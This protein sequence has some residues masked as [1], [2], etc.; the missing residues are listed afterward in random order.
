MEPDKKNILIAEDNRVMAGVMR[1]KLEQAGFFVVVCENGV[2][3]VAALGERQ[4]DVIV[5]DYQMPE[6]NGEQLC[7]HARQDPRH[8]EVP[9]FLVTAKRFELDIEA[10]TE[11]LSLEK[12][13]CKPFSPKQIVEMV[14][15]VLESTPV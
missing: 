4:F 5:T 3:A 8:A 1:F 10:L 13:L 6:M 7:R 15:D 12:V 11:E 2:Q 14:R 9:I